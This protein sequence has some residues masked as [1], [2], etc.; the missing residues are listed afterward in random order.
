MFAISAKRDNFIDFLFAFL[1]NK[2]LEKSTLKENNFFPLRV[3]LFLAQRENNRFDGI[4]S[5]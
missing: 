2:P 5:L 4:T 3:N 1:N